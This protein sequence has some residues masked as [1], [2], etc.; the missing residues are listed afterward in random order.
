VRLSENGQ[1][2]IPELSEQNDR[3]EAKGH[4][5]VNASSFSHLIGEEGVK[6]GVG[7]GPQISHLNYDSHVRGKGP[8]LRKMLDQKRKFHPKSVHAQPR[9]DAEKYAQNVDMKLTLLLLGSTN[10]NIS[11]I[12]HL[13]SVIVCKINIIYYITNTQNTYECEVSQLINY[14]L[15]Y[16]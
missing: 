11:V 5:K 10:S 6:D 13:F 1:H 8:T 7:D 4:H 16:Y 14:F 2:L 9:A 12:P 15:T 3:D